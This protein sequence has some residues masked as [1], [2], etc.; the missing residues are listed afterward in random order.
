MAMPTLPIPQNPK[1]L[2]YRL[3]VYVQSFSRKFG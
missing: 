2:P 1:G 3:F